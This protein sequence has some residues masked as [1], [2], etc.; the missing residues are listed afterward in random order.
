MTT[1]STASSATT[2][3]ARLGDTVRQRWTAAQRG[4]TELEQRA[5]TQWLNLPDHLRDALERLFD[6][7]KQRLDLPTRSEVSALSDR[8]DAFDRRLAAFDAARAE[9]RR[10]TEPPE[11]SRVVKPGAPTRPVVAAKRVRA[12]RPATDDGTP[13]A[14]TR[15]RAPKR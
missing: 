6:R 11:S 7:I 10:A 2:T 14:P 5:R 15:R 12:D 9:R 8:L 3:I 4:A 13:D 1:Q